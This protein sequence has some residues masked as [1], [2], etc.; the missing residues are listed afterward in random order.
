M[1]QG[2]SW[3]VAGKECSVNTSEQND[4]ALEV[5]KLVLR[6]W[7]NVEWFYARP[8]LLAL[9]EAGYELQKIDEAA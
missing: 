4:E 1:A 5:L 8:V 9:R 3:V 2:F 7:C 6:E